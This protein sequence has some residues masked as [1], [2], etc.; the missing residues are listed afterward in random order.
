M[1]DGAGDDEL[2]WINPQMSTPCIASGVV[3]IRGLP[4]FLLPPAD[5]LLQ[6]ET[7]EL[8]VAPN[9]RPAALPLRDAP[10]QRG[11][12]GD[13]TARGAGG[14]LTA[15]GAAVWHEGDPS[16]PSLP[17]GGHLDLTQ[18]R[19]GR[20]NSLISI[21]PHCHP[22]STAATLCWSRVTRW[23][24]NCHWGLPRS[25]TTTFRWIGNTRYS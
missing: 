4:L 22:R 25:A 1:V 16:R 14:R 3:F 18:C 9:S 12:R 6:S 10:R 11:G 13:A 8:G 15:L 5:S 2:N 20:N 24:L 23:I 7:T 17:F 19:R 21:R